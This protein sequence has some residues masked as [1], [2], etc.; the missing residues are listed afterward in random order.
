MNLMVPDDKGIWIRGWRPV[1]LAIMLATCL[2]SCNTSK[3]LTGD[4]ELLTGQ[5][6]VIE[7]PKSVR[8]RTDLTYQLSTIARQQPNG[9]FFFLWPREWFY[10][11]NSQPEDSS[12]INRFLRNTVGQ[13]PVLYSDSLSRRSARDMEDFMFRLGYFDARVYHEADRKRRRKVNLIYHVQAD[14]RRT[15]DSVVYTSPDPV[16]D[17]LLQ[18]AV[19]ASE[20]RS[21]EP[22][23]LNAFDREKTRL[24]RYMRNRG[25]SFFSIN[26]I[27]ELEIDT[28]RRRGY[29]DLFL[30]VLPPERGQRRYRVGE[31]TVYTDFSPLAPTAANFLR[32]TV[33]DGVRFLSRAPAFRMR[34]ELLRKNIFLKRGEYTRRDLLEKTNLGL[35]GLGIY[36]FVRINQQLD[37]TAENTLNYQIQLSL[38]DRMS[39]GADLDLN[40]TNRNGNFGNLGAGNLTGARNLI[41]I[42]VSPTFQNRNLLGGAE[43][44]VASVSAGIEVNP[45]AGSDGEFFNTVDLRANASLSLPRF[46]DSGIYGLLNKLPAPW[47]GKLVTDG[48]LRQLRERS[49]TRFSIGYENL[50]IRQFYA[51]TIFNARQG[52]DFRRSAT[53]NYRIN[54]LAVD[55]LD[56]AT[57]PAFEQILE[58]NQYL[59]RSFGEQYFL[60]FLFRD[61]EYTRIGLP[62]AKGRSLSFN[63]RFEVAGAELFAVNQLVNTL[64]DENR[65]W[66]PNADA[67]YAKYFLAEASLR[68][69]KSFTP[70]TRFVSRLLIG[71]GRPY[72]G[73]A[74]IPFVKQFFVGGANSMRAWAPRGLGPGGYVDP[75]S[76]NTDNNLRL[77]QTGDLRLELNLEYRFPIASFFK[78]A[79]FADIGNVW[80]FEEDENGERPGSQFRLTA[81]D[82]RDGTFRH[83]AFYRQLAVGAGTGLRVDL[84]YFIFRLDASIPVRYNYPNDGSGE[85]RDA[86]GNLI[87][88]NVFDVPE[89]AYW[90]DFG[91]FRFQDITWQLGLGYPF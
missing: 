54:H 45:F 79:I 28:S 36:R 50:L 23:D 2:T 9:N 52:Y 16:I 64:R 22:L 72:G 30:S 47:R 81:T 58:E 88:E 74:A 46:K 40:Y 55:I 77:F 27:D 90:R 60:S 83:E 65:T 32:D 43:L 29:A 37:S 20:L 19:V 73:T 76:L 25:Y 66:R 51:Y 3:Y 6:V 48:F 67:I 12:R 1:V 86:E 59:R 5:R 8:N 70:Q 82:G 21:G 80:T 85:I 49:N 78:G 71:A 56:P 31:V 38:N 63:G 89:S 41:G 34:P 24:S 17:S 69:Y 33:I 4:E 39:I 14:A 44:L 61:V 57:E 15:I 62:D 18:Q 75:L 91:A 53:T 68:Y 87:W 42:S 26:Y 11:K 35:N 7:D 13:Q 84:S 10:F